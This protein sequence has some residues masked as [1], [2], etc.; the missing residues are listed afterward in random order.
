[1]LGEG[2]LRCGRQLAIQGHIDTNEFQAGVKG[3]VFFQFQ[4]D[5]EVEANTKDNVKEEEQ[6]G[7]GIRPQQ[8]VINNLAGAVECKIEARM[9][10]GAASPHA[11]EAKHKGN[12]NGQSINKAKMH[13]SPCIYHVAGAEQLQLVHDVVGHSNLM[14]SRPGV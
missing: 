2:I 14:K 10:T 4:Q 11:A 8:G 1:M 13:N 7:N 12:V 5:V 3:S 6:V 9:S